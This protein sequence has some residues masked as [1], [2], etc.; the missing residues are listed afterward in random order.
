M[1]SYYSIKK[2]I[3]KKRKRKNIVS[4]LNIKMSFNTSK[5]DNTLEKKSFKTD[6]Y[7]QISDGE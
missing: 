3:K 2:Y 1:L 7:F 6:L 5:M 4:E